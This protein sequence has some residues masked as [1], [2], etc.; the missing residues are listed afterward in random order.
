MTTTTFG[1]LFAGVG[2]FDLGLEAAGWS[3]SWQVEWDKHATA[4]LARHWPTVP[5]WGDVRDVDGATLLPVDLITFGSPCQD[6]SVAGRRAGLDGDRSSLFYEATR[7]IREMR[8]ATGNA[9]PRWAVWEN[10][11]GALD[12]NGGADFGRVLD[13]LADAGALV[14]EWTVLDARWFGVPQRRRRVFVVA[15]F[16]PAT[17]DRCPDPLLPV[18]TSGSGYPS[19]GNQPRQAAPV[20]VARGIGSD[21]PARPPALDSGTGDAVVALPYG[22]GNQAGWREGVAPL[23]AAGGDL[24][25]GSETLVVSFVWHKGYSD[26]VDQPGGPVH[27]LTH[28]PPAVALSLRQ[29]VDGSTFLS[30]VHPP[31]LAEGGAGREPT[32]F[33]DDSTVRRLTPIEC[34]RLMGW[35]DDH[36]RYRAD[37][38]EQ[39]ET[40]RYKQ[41]GNGVVA[42]V[43]EWIGRRL[44]LADDSTNIDGAPASHHYKEHP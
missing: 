24:G 6:L 39:A 20:A 16:D 29:K 9:F 2:G 13:E 36:T 22:G 26:I 38:T 41:A 17:A 28:K 23:R 27:T 21:Q 14:I 31:L 43:A 5:R 35:P 10:V 40:H 33:I 4:V 7:I 42:P 37:G 8:D 3:C 15:C 11:A 1:S 32:A 25:G 18:R 44:L 34:E 30:T 19:P 12:S